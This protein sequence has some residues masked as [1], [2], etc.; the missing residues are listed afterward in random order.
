MFTKQ[1]I[2]IAIAGVGALAGLI[3]YA[4]AS[5]KSSDGGSAQAGGGLM[6]PLFQSAALPATVTDSGAGSSAGSSGSGG[7]SVSDQL[8]LSAL[9]D[10]LKSAITTQATTQS[11]NN[12]ATLGE[13]LFAQIADAQKN[14]SNM[15]GDFSLKDGAVNFNWTSSGPTVVT[16]P[17][18][19]APEPPVTNPVQTVQPINVVV[20][21]PG[22]PTYS[23]NISSPFYFQP[24][25]PG[26]L[27]SMGVTNRTPEN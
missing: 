5:A 13:T 11:N 7:S 26:S 20:T 9:F 18:V 14:N 4:R 2:G 21:M 25:D 15:H 1:E 27:W 24:I 22:I 12:T 8:G 10:T 17:P 23:P 3:Y 6:Y 19:P 16:P